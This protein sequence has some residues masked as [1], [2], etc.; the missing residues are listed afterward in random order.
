M[1]KIVRNAGACFAA[2]C[3]L[4]ACSSSKKLDKAVYTKPDYTVEDVRNLEIERIQ[5]VVENHPVEALWRAYLVNDDATIASCTDAVVNAYKEAYGSEDYFTALYYYRSLDAVGYG[6]RDNLG[7]SLEELENRYYKDVPGLSAPADAAARHNSISNSEDIAN[8]INGTVTIWVDQGIKVERGVG[9][10]D[11]VI[12]SGFFIAKDGYIVTN[13]HVI[14]NVVDTK[15][16]GVAK[17]FIKLSADS[18]TRIP[19]KVIGWDSVVDLALLK[20]EIDAP[21]VFELGSSS[22]LAAGDKIY[23]IGSPLGLDR[24]LTS[25]IVSSTNRKLSFS[26]NVFQIDAA[27]NAGNS[28]GPC[29]DVNGRVQAIVFAGISEYQGLNFAIPVE[30]LKSDL[31]LLYHGGERVHPWISAYGH[32]KRIGSAQVGVEMQYVLPSGSAGRSDLNTGDTI[33]A[34]NGRHVGTMEDLHGIFRQYLPETIVK[35]TAL[36]EAGDSYSR[37]VYLEKRP[38]YPGYTIYQRD[39]V[40]QSFLPIF[41]MQLE[42]VSTFSSRKYAISRLITGGIADE[43]G[44]SENDP[45]DIHRIKVADNKST[46]YAELYTKNRKKGYLDV[47]IAL[48]ASL[49]NPYYF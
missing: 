38:K 45:V 15:Y 40:E 6:S 2:A 23:A 34:I 5:K 48:S 28:G 7:I 29:I 3:V 20:A 16:D 21:Y 11:R 22:G 9:Y 43:S 49:D 30:Y 19:A 33:V 10:A 39:L 12:G 8:Y 1:N 44:F 25:G 36:D 14:A 42:S 17:L 13:H 47:G 31:P 46:I 27:V 4:A 37:L 26:G 24:T 35:V 41:G 18:E 32:T